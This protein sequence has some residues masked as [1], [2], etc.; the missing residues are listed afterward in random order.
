[1]ESSGKVFAI[2]LVI[3]FLTSTITL[4]AKTGWA[5]VNS[6][7]SYF[8]LPNSNAT[9]ILSS[10]ASYIQATYYPAH[11]STTGIYVP[12]SWEFGYSVDYLSISAENS[13]ITITAFDIYTQNTTEKY[14]Y[15]YLLL[16]EL[17]S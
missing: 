16:A 15:K 11:D 1:M 17:H 12:E 7:A 2:M 13:N 14:L 10:N 6:Q 3:V 9:I 4:S 8:P 5:T